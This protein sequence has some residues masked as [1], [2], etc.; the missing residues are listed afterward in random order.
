ME[1]YD[2]GNNLIEN[3]LETKLEEKKSKTNIR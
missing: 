3:I 1:N 2:R